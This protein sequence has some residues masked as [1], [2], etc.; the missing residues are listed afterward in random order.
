[1][2]TSKLTGTHLIDKKQID[3][4]TKLIEDHKDQQ[5]YLFH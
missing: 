4:R 1:M 3:S 2:T 5:T